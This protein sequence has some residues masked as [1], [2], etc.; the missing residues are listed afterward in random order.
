MYRTRPSTSLS[1]LAVSLLAMGA[2]SALVAVPAAHAKEPDYCS[3]IGGSWDDATSTC[4]FMGTYAAG[5]GTLEI[6]SGI[7]DLAASSSTCPN[8]L[9]FSLNGSVRVDGGAT[10][11][12]RPSFNCTAE[13]IHSGILLG[14]SGTGIVNFGTIIVDP[15]ISCS[16]Q[17]STPPICLGILNHG[18]I[19]NHG[20]ISIGGT[21]SC[22][23]PV[24]CAGIEDVGTGTIKDVNCGTT[25][26]TGEPYL[27]GSVESSGICVNTV[28][29][30]SLAAFFALLSALVIAVLL[31]FRRKPS[32]PGTRPVA[33]NR[34]LGGKP[35]VKG[36]SI[37]IRRQ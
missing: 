16:F 29:I 28:V 11:E 4:T 21:Y 13:G 5:S 18:A 7:L 8:Q 30:L 20:V 3:T 14:G 33:S 34:R 24:T 26:P 22:Q 2:V 1:A 23:S 32:S 37:P 12:I 25:T 19:S 17:S 9:L 36:M 35:R 31:V 15:T 27:V 6:T 10:L